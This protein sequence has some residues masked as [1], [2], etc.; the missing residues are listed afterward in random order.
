MKEK[1]LTFLKGFNVGKTP[2]EIGM[3]LGKTYNQAS[4]SVSGALKS[5]VD[6]GAVSKKKLDGKV[7]YELKRK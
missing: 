2:T 4:S 7:L 1:V 5:L 6:E 3:G